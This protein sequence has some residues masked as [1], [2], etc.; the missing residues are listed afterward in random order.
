MK[1]KILLIIWFSTIFF[2][3]YAQDPLKEKGAGIYKIR[4]KDEMAKDEAKLTGKGKAAFEKAKND[5]K[6]IKDP[7]FELAPNE[8]MNYDAGELLGIP[9]NQKPDMKAAER[10]NE[11][12]KKN[13]EEIKGKLKEVS[14][15]VSQLNFAQAIAISVPYG[16][17]WNT[18]ILTDVKN[19][20]GCGSCWAFAACAA[21]EHSY[22]KIF[23]TKYDL[24]EQDVVSC[25]KNCL[26]GDCGSCNGGWSDC[27]FD[28]MKCNGIALE[29]TYPYNISASNTCYSKPKS[30][31]AY[32]WGQLYPGRFP[33]TAEIKYYINTFGAVVTYMKAGL[34]TFLSYGGGVYNGYASN[35]SNSI[36]HAVVIVG[37][38]DALNAW[39]IKNSWGPGWGPYGGYAYVGYNSCNI[40]KFVYWVYPKS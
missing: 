7:K 3:S 29:T 30:K 12:N 38:C 35:S 36:D 23:G 15:D 16:C 27:A 9:E 20:A 8:I 18:A 13:Q 4:T 5:F 17:V 39:I 11:E 26:N 40:G 6:S 32:T 14:I 37:Y 1:T 28:F 25:G 33:T 19:Q 31:W 2:G 21:F 22:A 34:S 24:S 10:Q